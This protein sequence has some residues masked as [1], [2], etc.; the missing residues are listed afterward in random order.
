MFALLKMCGSSSTRG[1]QVATRWMCCG[2]TQCVII[3]PKCNFSPE[4]LYLHFIQVHFST[5]QV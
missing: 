3:A 4:V 1:V 2:N 5:L